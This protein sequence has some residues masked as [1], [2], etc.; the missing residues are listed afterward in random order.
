MRKYLLLLALYSLIECAGAHAQ[1]VRILPA[2]GERGTLGESQ[3]LPLVKI[4]SKVLRLAPGGVIYDQSNR[5]IL[6]SN[7]PP[8]AAVLYTKDLN[9]DIQRIYILSEQEQAR[10]DRAGK[11]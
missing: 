5:F 8:A 1:H 11:R 7:L 10:L 3:P 4:G 9:G 2:Q 6:H